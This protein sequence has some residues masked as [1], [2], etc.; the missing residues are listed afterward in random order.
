[1]ALGANHLVPQN[2]APCLKNAKTFM[3]DYCAGTKGWP[4]SHIFL[5]LPLS[6][7]RNHRQGYLVFELGELIT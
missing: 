7:D 5:E 6:I 1:M 3:V 2:E 4:E